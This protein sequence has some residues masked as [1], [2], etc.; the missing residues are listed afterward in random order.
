MD[1]FGQAPRQMAMPHMTLGNAWGVGSWGEELWFVR[2][3]APM[4]LAV[5][6]LV[7]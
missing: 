2:A 4:T 1:I 6:V 5:V 7:E 3:N